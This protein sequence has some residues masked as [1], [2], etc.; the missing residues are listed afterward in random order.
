MS[1]FFHNLALFRFK[2]AD[3]FPIF[4]AKIFLKSQHWSLVTLVA[5][6]FFELRA[7][8]REPS[9]RDERDQVGRAAPEQHREQLREALHQR[10][11]RVNF[12]LC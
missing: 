1:N 4:W 8:G 3:F 6:V 7:G 5:Q 11:R 2:N 9:H 10:A 12:K